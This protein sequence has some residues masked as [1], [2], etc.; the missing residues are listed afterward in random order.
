MVTIPAGHFV[1]GTPE[2]EAAKVGAPYNLYAHW[3]LPLHKVTIGKAFALGRYPV[4]VGEYRQFADAVGP[5]VAGSAWRFPGIAQSERDP[6]VNV[7]WDEAKAYADWLSKKTGQ[8]YRLPT[9]AE[10][11]YAA[12]AGTTTPAYWGPI[13]GGHAPCA[14]CGSQWSNKRTAPVGQFAPN[15]WGL[16]DMLGNV[17]QWVDDCW[18]PNYYNAPTDG[19]S[20]TR[21]DCQF[22]VARGGDWHLSKAFARSGL[23]SRDYETYHGIM[24]GFRVAKTLPDKAS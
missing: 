2:A 5:E 1:M 17:L 7:N 21:G 23:R 4:T 9:E 19:S 22:R 13:E 3:E 24:V 15:P 6:V 12:R 11:E 8:T 20:W 18:T 10:F 14:D 16:S